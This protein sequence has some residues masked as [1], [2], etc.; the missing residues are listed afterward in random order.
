MVFPALEFF[1]PNSTGSERESATAR[2]AAERQNALPIRPHT[3]DGTAL[4]QPAHGLR[5]S[6]LSEHS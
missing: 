6:P 4:A 1:C 2:V 5:I 3:E